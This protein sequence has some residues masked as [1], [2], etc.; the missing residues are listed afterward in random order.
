MD[1]KYNVEIIID[2]D[3]KHNVSRYDKFS[4]LVYSNY[5]MFTA[6]GKNKYKF[7]IGE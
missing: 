6:E 3:E 2:V 4:N 1:I 5:L 7:F